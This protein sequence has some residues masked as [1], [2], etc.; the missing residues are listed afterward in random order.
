MFT[1]ANNLEGFSTW[2][3]KLRACS[4]SQDNIKGGLEATGHDSCNILGFLLN[5]GPAAYVLNPLRTN[6]YRKSLSL[7]KT[8]TDQVDAQTI[9]AMLLSDTGLKP[10]T[11][12]AYHNEELK[13]LTRSRFDQVKERAK[14]KQSVSGLVYILFSEFEKLVPTLHMA[15][16]YTL[17]SEF[18][19]AK[20]VVAAHLTRLKALLADASKGH[21]G[22]DMAAEIRNAARYSIGS[23]M[24]ANSLDCSTPSALLG[25]WTLRLKKL[26]PRSRP[27]VTFSGIC[28]T[29]STTP[30]RNWCS[31]S[32]LWKN[33]S[34]LTLRLLDLPQ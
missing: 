4:T 26:K 31:S 20:Q 11:D 22:R 15:S 8:K 9:A 27:S 21:Y 3:D 5:N 16:V 19:E 30:P 13:S 7:R 29:T 24:S 14:R 25:S 6:L 33:P 34:S 1:I 10:C 32:L 18:P 17:L 23:R 28:A 12:T 2:L